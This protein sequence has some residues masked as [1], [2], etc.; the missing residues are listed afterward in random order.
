MGAAAAAAWNVVTGV[1]LSARLFSTTDEIFWGWG[2]ETEWEVVSGVVGNG[3]GL[4]FRSG[5]TELIGGCLGSRCGVGYVPTS[6]T[7]NIM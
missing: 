3:F 5:L 4:G 6:D 7:G 1:E 2:Q